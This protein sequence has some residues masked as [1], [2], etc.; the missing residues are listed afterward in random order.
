VLNSVTNS[1]AITYTVKNEAAILP[2]ALKWHFECGAAKIFIFWDG[3]TDHGPELV[4]GL[5]N[6]QAQNSVNPRDVSNLPEWVKIIAPMWEENMDVRKRINTLVAARMAAA[7]NIQWIASID[8][9]ELM[10]VDT[11]S[12]KQDLSGLFANISDKV[13]QILLRNLEVLPTD[14]N[15]ENPFADCTYFLSRHPKTEVIRRYCTAAFRKIFSSPKAHAWFE[16]KFYRA[17][18][19]GLFPPIVS[20]PENGEKLYRS[21]YLG[22][23]NYKSIMRTSRADDYNFNTHKWQRYRKSPASIYK[24]NVLHYDLFNATYFI[25]KFR[26]RQQGILVKA[27]HVRY[28]L[29]MIARSE[30][31]DMAVNFFNEQIVIKDPDYLNRLISSKIV[32]K[33]ESPSNF[34]KSHL[35]ADNGKINP[36]ING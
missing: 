14:P 24:G 31:R 35:A 29:A 27:F 13:D 22:Y 25:E 36:L 15:V 19:I 30:S 17:R 18:F 6:V 4:R 1:F 10:I 2:D 7:E 23:S 34:F 9:D 26:Q 8:P 33:I 32:Q 28:E 16:H 21:Y 11:T 3:T 12:A 5:L 20:N